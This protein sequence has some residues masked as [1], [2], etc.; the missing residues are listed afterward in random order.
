[1]LTVVVPEV[2]LRRPWH[3]LLH[4]RTGHRL[5]RALRALPGVVVTSIPVHVVE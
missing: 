5:R 3:R 1:M 4:S 2:V